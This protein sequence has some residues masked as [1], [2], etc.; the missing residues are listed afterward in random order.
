MLT[1][2]LPGVPVTIHW[3][4]LLVAVFGISFYDDPFEIAA[5]TIAVFVAVLLHEAGHAYTSKAY[6]ATQVAI[7][8]FALGGYTTWLPKP[9]MTPGKRFVVSAAGSALGIAGGLIIVGL[10]SVGFFEGVPNWAVAFFNTFIIVG[11]FWGVLNWIPLLPLDGGHMLH[12]ALA[13]FWPRQAVQIAVG[14][15]LVVGVILIGAA[16]YFGEL[17]MAFFLIFIV[18]SGLRSRPALEAQNQEQQPEV[19]P[20]DRRYGPPRQYEQPRPYPPAPPTPPEE[21]EPPAFPI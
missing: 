14:V 2:A 13:I 17:F 6:G 15:S 16:F 12:H 4:F 5:W 19:I 9:G 3:S 11:L 18:I 7:T 21:R 20:P 1:F 8:L 10:N